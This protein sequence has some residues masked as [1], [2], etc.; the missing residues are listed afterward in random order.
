MAARTLNLMG[1]QATI[2]ATS[3]DTDGAFAMLEFLAAPG[4]SAQP[5]HV[6]TREAECLHV[7][8][9]R[10]MVTVGREERLVEPG[11]F[12][13]MPRGSM[14]GWRN[15]DPFPARFLIMLLPGGGERYYLDLAAVLAAG[16]PNTTETIAALMA[17]HGIRA[18]ESVVRLVEDQRATV[19]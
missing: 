5:L 1:N 2:R 14:H 7:L 12:V 16:A 13:F 19:S 17:S 18:V 6:H 3:D 8:E 10:L 9:G 11:G 15:P 4:A